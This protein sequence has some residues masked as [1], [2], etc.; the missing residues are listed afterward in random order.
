MIRSALLARVYL[1]RVLGD[2]PL[3]AGLYRF[4]SPVSAA[5]VRRM[6]REGEVATYPVTVIEGSTFF[7]TA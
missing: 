2:P 3:Q 6:L 1:S 4:T 7:E 5:T